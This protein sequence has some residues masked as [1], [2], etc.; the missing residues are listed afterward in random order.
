MNRMENEKKKPLTRWECAN[1]SI[2]ESSSTILR[3]CSRCKLV[4]YCGT[5]CQAQHWKKGGHKHNCVAPDLRRP[6]PMI[7]KV[8]SGPKCTICM[9]EMIVKESMKLPCSHVFHQRCIEAMRERSASQV[10]PIC[11][12]D[13][14]TW[15]TCP[16]GKGA[17]QGR[18]VEIVEHKS[19][20]PFFHD[21]I[22]FGRTFLL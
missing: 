22:K 20:V 4:R 13:L 6:Q 2:P 5:E 3:P 10:C 17:S 15:S 14:P 19:K 11:R 18:K 7:E 12:S 1:C 21:E 16:K 8:N 9:G